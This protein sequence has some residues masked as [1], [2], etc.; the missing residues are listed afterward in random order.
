M[1]MTVIKSS[2][3]GEVG[4]STICAVSWA[5]Q[6]I[7][8]WTFDCPVLIPADEAPDLSVAVL[9]LLWSLSFH[10]DTLFSQG[11]HGEPFDLF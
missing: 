10:G 2:I 11:E 6:L 8:P 5:F 7:M 4:R 1:V 3:S 9:R